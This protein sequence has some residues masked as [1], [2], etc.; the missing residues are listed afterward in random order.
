M[1]VKKSL[2]DTLRANDQAIRNLAAMTG[3]PVPP[4]LLNNLPPKQVRAAA[5]YEGSESE[6]QAACIQ[7]LRAHPQV[8]MCLRMNSGAAEWETPKGDLVPIFFHRW[9]KAPEDMLMVDLFGFMH[10]AGDV[11]GV[12]SRK[13]PFAI[14]CKE[15]QWRP[16]LG[17]GAKLGERNPLFIKEKKQWA[18]IQFIKSIGGVGG[19]VTSDLQAQAIIEERN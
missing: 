5:K 15:S 2:S 7:Q 11:F 9:I 17:T 18:F 3:K 13:I 14:E 16:A 1:R 10:E 12:R 6:V 19:F 4:E 8:I